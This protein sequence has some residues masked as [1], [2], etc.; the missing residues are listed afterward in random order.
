MTRLLNTRILASLAMIVFVGAVWAGATGAF[1]SDTETST[2]NTFSAGDIDL[3][4]DNESYVTNAAG[5]LVASPNN[6]W[7]MSNLT[8]QLFFSFADVKPGDI[9]EDTISVHAGSNNAWAC[10]AADIT[11]TPENTLVDP[12]VDASDAGPANGDNGELQN[13]LNF[14]FWNDD[15][16]NVLET[17]ETQ[18]TQLTGPA[19]TIFNGNW[20]PI[21]D[22][23]NGT[24]I[25]GNSTR[26]IGKAWCFGTL[27]ASTTAQDGLGKTG[28]NGPLVRGTGFTCDGAGDNNIA[29]TDG[30]SVDVSFQAVQTRNNGQFLC[31]SL[32]P[33][34]GGGN[35]QRPTVGAALASY[36]APTGGQCN[37]TVDDNGGNPALDTIGEG[38]AAAAP[39]QTVCVLAGTYNEDVNVNK[40]ITLAGAGQATTIINGQ[41][42]GQTGA[43]GIAANNVTVEGFQINAASGAVAAL[44]IVGVHSGANILSNKITAATGGSAADTVGGQTNHTFSNNEFVGAA[45]QPIVYVNGLASVNVASTNVDFTQNSFTGAGSL[46]LG[47]E[48]GASSITLNKFAAATSF[49]DVED[50]EGGNNYNQNN[51]NDAGLNLQHSENANTGDN[52]ITNAENNWWG[53]TDPSDGNVNANVDVDFTPFEGSA[54]PQN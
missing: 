8:N 24:A 50:W 2:G 30:I 15:G 21:A 4:I 13:F 51:F 12:E 3:Q 25:A 26:Y 42:G 11:A 54:F 46:A 22:S 5:V 47:Q 43:V 48:A 14:T 23:A 52:G 28:T 41:L 7:G 40:S 20:L 6:S 53:D 36:V 35:A 29:Q 1:F 38:I 33:F 32:P 19:G 45:G 37:V 49:T 10:M 17:G 44:R 18:I 16:D 39:G 27:T 31:S 34:Q 9:G